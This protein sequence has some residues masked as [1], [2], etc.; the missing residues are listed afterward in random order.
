MRYRRPK[1]SI[2]LGTVAAVVVASPVAVLVGGSAPNFAVDPTEP[3]AITATT[4]NQINLN[5]VPT[6]VLNLVKSGLADAGV[7]LPPI[8]VSG[9]KLPDI[10][11]QIPPG[12]L[13]TDL[14]PSTTAPGTITTSPSVPSSTEASSSAPAPATGDDVPEGAIVKEV[15]QEDPFSMVGLTWQGV[16]N[17]TAY[18]RAKQIDGSWGPWVSADRVDGVS[19]KDP[20]KQGTEPVWVGKT[21]LVQIAVTNDGVAAPGTGTGPTEG[22]ATSSPGGSAPATTTDPA[23]IAPTTTSTT[24]TTFTTPPVP[25]RTDTS[26][27][28][29]TA[30]PGEVVPQAFTPKQE[31][32]L[33][34][35]GAPG[36]NALQQAISTISAALITPGTG[37][38]L[39]SQPLA[40]DPA[41]PAAAPA[42]PAVAAPSATPQVITRAQWG[43]DESIRCSE[44]TYDDTLKETVVHHTAGTN[45]YTREQSAEIVRGIYAYHAQTLGWCDIGYNVLVDKYGQIFEGTAGGLDKNVQGTHTGGFNKDTMGL[46]LMGNLNEMAPSPEMLAAA[47]SFLGWRLRLAG[48]DPRGTG[49]VVSQGFDGALFAAGETATLPVISGH[50][51]FY[52][53]ECPG[54]L[55]YEAL[56]QIRDIAASG[57]AIVAPPAAPAPVD[58]APVQSPV[59]G[60]E[61]PQVLSTT[62]TGAIAQQWMATGGPTGD[63]GNA[64]TTE[65][66]TPDGNAKFADF[67]NG[68]I[69]WSESTGAQIIKGAIAKAWATMGFEN[70]PLGLPTSSETT[71]PDGVTQSFQGGTLV[72]NLVTG[73]VRVLRTYIDTFNDTYD[74]QREAAAVPTAPPA[75]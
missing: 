13:P 37:A 19:A 61:N 65:Q 6:I 2:V 4:I 32:L 36:Q 75:G 54:N 35:T 53:T 43:A 56:P 26:I 57:A 38:V 58:T 34:T 51:D 69:Y 20:N 16:A 59:S 70:S 67:E 62:D 48:L 72:W 64:V 30:M 12:L 17:T 73:I 24:S 25:K 7:T 47:G 23:G 66:T 71:G 33:T 31:P 45:D 27:P 14:L 39:G 22:S 44:P 55:A 15:G 29:S 40:A 9:I 11:L 63:L 50:R 8:D 52:S 21:N 42:P 68:K 1:P 18:V 46:S 60:T 5:E 49:S 3:P 10:P 28:T 41:A 74:A